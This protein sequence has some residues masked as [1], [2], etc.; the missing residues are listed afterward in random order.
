MELPIRKSEKLAGF[1]ALGGPEHDDTPE[2]ED[3]RGHELPEQ[4]GE[5]CGIRISVV[6]LLS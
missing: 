2:Q 6:V 3:E 1:E 4:K 5:Y